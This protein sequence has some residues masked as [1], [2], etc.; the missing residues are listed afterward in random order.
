MKGSLFTEKHAE[1]WKKSMKNDFDGMKSEMKEDLK[2]LTEEMKNEIGA[3]FKKMAEENLEEMK[4]D[5]ARQKKEMK[6]HFEEMEKQIRKDLFLMKKSN[7][8]VLKRVNERDQHLKTI[9]YFKAE[10]ERLKMIK[11]SLPKKTFNEECY[12]LFSVLFIT[13]K[14][15]DLYNTW[16]QYSPG[17]ICKVCEGGNDKL[18][19]E[20]K[21]EGCIYSDGEPIHQ[22]LSQLPIPCKFF[23]CLH[24][25]I[26]CK[27]CCEKEK[28]LECPYCE[29]VIQRV[30]Y[31]EQ[32]IEPFFK[33]LYDG[34]ETRWRWTVLY[35][36]FE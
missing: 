25:N 27:N 3:S 5:F 29:E 17:K 6:T 10:N 18:N 19:F 9:A 13:I 28:Y 16:K 35:S 2:K 22:M 31:Q 11:S 20:T 33:R 32:T 7:E 8:E 24:T 36:N 4:N 30:E 34:Y 15:K 26:V 23:P 14:M 12:K 1:E 21:F